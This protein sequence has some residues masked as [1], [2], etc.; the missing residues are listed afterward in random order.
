MW[1]TGARAWAPQHPFWEGWVAAGIKTGEDED[2]PRH[3]GRPECRTGMAG[4][5]PRTVHLGTGLWAGKR[6]SG[7]S[8]PAP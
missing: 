5:A 8:C 7:L 1:V 3:S 2:A 6:P 4:A